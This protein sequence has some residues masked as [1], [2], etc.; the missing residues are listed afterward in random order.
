VPK[1]RYNGRKEGRKE[2]NNRW[3]GGKGEGKTLKG[4]KQWNND[5]PGFYDS[6][7]ASFCDGGPQ[8]KG[9]K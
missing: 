5:H 1:C 4:K 8:N 2:G 7:V 6:W 9:L 3:K